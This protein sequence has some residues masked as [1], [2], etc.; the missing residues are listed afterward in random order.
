MRRSARLAA[1][2]ALAVAL[3]LFFLGCPKGT[4]PYAD[5][6]AAPRS[7]AAPL[8]VAFT[9]ASDPGSGNNILSWDWNFGDGQASVDQN[10]SHTY[11][12][13]GMYTVS[14][15]VTSSSGIDS[16]VKENYVNVQVGPSANFVGSPTSGAAPLAVEFQ[17]RSAAGSSPI[18]AWSWVFGD[19]YTGSERNPT[20]VYYSPGTYS[21]T[22]TV[23]TALGS[24]TRTREDYVT[25]TAQ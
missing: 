7:G 2:T 6:T 25:V 12:F 18:T 17:D 21:V 19:G 5:F 22:L 1:A 24:D 4:P 14:L 3:G 8:T 20:H 10:P 13:P 11:N 16:V 15:T 23:A 9:D